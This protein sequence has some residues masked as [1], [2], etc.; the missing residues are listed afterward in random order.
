M[1]LL[2]APADFVALCLSMHLVVQQP[3]ADYPRMQSS[4]YANLKSL[5]GL[6]EAVGYNSLDVVQC[7]LLC[8]F[9]EM[10]HGMFPAATISLGT[11]AR[12]ARS[13]GLYSVQDEPLRNATS[14][15]AEEERRRAWW[16]LLNLD[17]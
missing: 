5:L 8:I 6:L 14:R 2:S 16:M 3:S 12:I 17:R 11:C 9:Y 10:G 15:V 7:R 13:L 1:I 4:L